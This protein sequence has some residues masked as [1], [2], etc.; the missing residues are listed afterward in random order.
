MSGSLWF[1]A[2]VDYLRVTRPE[3]GLE[4]CYLSLGDRES[5][6]RNERLA[7]VGRC[8]L[9]VKAL[10]EELGVETALEMHPGGHFQDVPMRVE[11]GLLALV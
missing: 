4:R 11:K 7:A 10:L 5:K 1:D 8:T 2:F 3:G 9:E 6:G